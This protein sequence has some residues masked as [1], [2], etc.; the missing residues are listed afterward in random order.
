MN[1]ETQERVFSIIAKTQH[2]PVETVA[3]DKTFEE[4]KID[5]LDAIN[6]VFAVEE[7]FKIAVPDDQLASLR[8]IRDVVDGI[9]ILLAKAAS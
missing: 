4:L 3:I 7:E 2:I 1:S 9:E 5:S 8:S 6:I